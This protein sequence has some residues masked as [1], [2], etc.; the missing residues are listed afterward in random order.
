[1]NNR[2][3]CILALPFPRKFMLDRWL[4][5]VHTGRHEQTKADQAYIVEA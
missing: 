2:R 4:S 1:M 5:F 3:V